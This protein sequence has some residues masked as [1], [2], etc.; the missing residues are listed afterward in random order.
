VTGDE[1]ER[2]QAGRARR[3]IF[4]VGMMGCGKSSVGPVLAR[5]LGRSFVDTDA[6]VEATAGIPIR[7]IF[8]RDGEAAFRA[9]ERRAIEDSATGD[10]VVALGGGAIAQPGAPER[11]AELGVVVY[12]RASVASL[13]ARIGE[14]A[15]RPLL[16]GLDEAGRWRRLEELLGE[17]EAAYR[18]ADIVVET[19][20]LDVDA[21]AGEVERMLAR[22]G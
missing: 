10:A 7:E 17:R 14:G 11:L 1:R 2:S 20:G 13:L 15:E 18:R 22:R 8:A 9:L 5:R 4:L 21:A 12:L 19:D 6:R 16:A 3:P